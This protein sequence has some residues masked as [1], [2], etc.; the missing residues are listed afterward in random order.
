MGEEEEQ[1]EEKEAV[2]AASAR[3]VLEAAAAAAA[4]PSCV[5]LPQSQGRREG[6][7]VVIRSSF[8]YRGGNAAAGHRRLRGQQDGERAAQGQ[9]GRALQVPEEE[10]QI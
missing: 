5:S 1:E 8:L 3:K 7:T 2:A 6:G 10:A 4:R 9:E